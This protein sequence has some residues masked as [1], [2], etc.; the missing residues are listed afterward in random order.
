[1][2]RSTIFEVYFL[3]SAENDL[4][5]IINY[6]KELSPKTAFEYYRHIIARTTQLERFPE[7]GRIVPELLD[8][9]IKTYR[10]LI[11][12]HYRIIYRIDNK[13]VFVVRILDS[14]NL[15]DLTLI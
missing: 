12:K 14:R 5:K 3:P 11:Y 13:K 10:E 2:K 7:S 4:D 6:Y 8:E 15:M 1:M 9:N